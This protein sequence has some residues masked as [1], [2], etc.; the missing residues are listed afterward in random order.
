MHMIIAFLSRLILPWP[1]WKVLFVPWMVC[2]GLRMV[3]KV[4][5]MVFLA[6]FL[7]VLILVL[8]MVPESV[9]HCALGRTL[10]LVIEMERWL[11]LTIFMV[12][13]VWVVSVISSR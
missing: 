2:K 6:Y 13:W 10:D 9:A 11:F 5:K 4:S 3:A 12:V 7:F 8:R 1:I